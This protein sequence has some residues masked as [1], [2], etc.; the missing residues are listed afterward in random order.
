MREFYLLY[1][2]DERVQPLVAQIGWSYNL[3]ILSALQGADKWET[4][5]LKFL[6]LCIHSCE[7]PLFRNKVAILA[8]KY[9]KFDIN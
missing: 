6:L 7:R 3:A 4:D 5:A 8:V 2:E 9:V 1:H